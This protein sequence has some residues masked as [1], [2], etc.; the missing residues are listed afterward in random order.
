LLELFYL[1]GYLNQLF[2]PLHFRDQLELYVKTNLSDCFFEINTITHYSNT[3][4]ACV[5]ARKFIKKGVIKYLCGIL[6]LLTEE[7]E[8]TLAATSR[9]F[10]IVIFSRKKFSFL[11]LGPGRFVNHNC[12]ANAK[13]SPTEDGMQAVA[14]RYID[15]GE[16]ITVSYGSHYFGENNCECLCATCASLQRNG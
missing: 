6:I 8:Q 1:R 2:M 9:D 4:E 5:T 14:I 3:P 12:E 7:E 13:L 15:V 11:F 16:E 10:S